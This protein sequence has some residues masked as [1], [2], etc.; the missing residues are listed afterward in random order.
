MKERSS[1]IAASAFLAVAL[2]LTGCQTTSGPGEKSSFGPIE[3]P[4][5]RPGEIWVAVGGPVSNKGV[6]WFPEGST[7]ADVLDWAKLDPI[8]PPHKVRLVDPDGHQS[9]SRSM[10]D[11]R[12]NWSTSKSNTAHGSWCHLTGALVL[13]PVRKLRSNHDTQPQTNEL[14]RVDAVQ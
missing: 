2:L 8:A 14:N 9:V 4:P 1:Q 10:G 6:H 3:V 11:P 7:L 5:G 12:K 13:A